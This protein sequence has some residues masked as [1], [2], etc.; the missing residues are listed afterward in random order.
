MKIWITVPTFNR[1]KIAEVSLKQLC[2]HKGAH[3]LHVSDDWSTEYSPNIFEQF[4]DQVEKV[5]RKMGIHHLRC[6]E[7]RKF[8]NERSEDLLYMTDSDTVH[9]PN[10]ADRLIELYKFKYPTTIYNTQHHFNSSL[11]RHLLEQYCPETLNHGAILRRTMPGVSQLFDREMVTKIVN[12]LDSEGDPV[13]AWD[14][15]VIECLRTPCVTSNI[16]FLEHFGGPGS[17]HNKT[18]D[19]DRAYNPT[20]YLKS[21]RPIVIDYLNSDKTINDLNI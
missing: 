2:N 18:L 9:D 14:Y 17:I 3:T 12:Y 21:I 11:P 7:F 15:R 16:S 20:E 19:T 4:S 13:Y 1:K 10:F 5:P 6:W 8:L